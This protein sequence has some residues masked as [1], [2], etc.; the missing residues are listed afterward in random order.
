MRDKNRI[1][2]IV[3][4]VEETWK[5]VPDLRLGQLLLNIV[6]DEKRLYYIEDDDLAKE[7][8]A[9]RWP[10]DDGQPG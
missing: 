4:Q 8:D 3:R 10:G 2:Y 5:R 9:F 7:L 1:P 6:R